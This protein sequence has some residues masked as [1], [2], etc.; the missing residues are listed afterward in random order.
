MFNI[1][2]MFLTVSALSFSPANITTAQANKISELRLY[3]DNGQEL[4]SAEGMMPEIVVTAEY[5]QTSSTTNQPNKFQQINDYFTF[6]VNVL[7]VL[8]FMGMGITTL[9]SKWKRRKGHKKEKG[10]FSL[11]PFSN[12]NIDLGKDYAC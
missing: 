1:G 10:P 2:T 12:K 4:L 11:P 8:F 9:L 3:A 6:I 7:I 5:P